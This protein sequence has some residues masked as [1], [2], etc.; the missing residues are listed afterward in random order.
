MMEVHITNSTLVIKF[1]YTQLSLESLFPRP[2]ILLDIQ[3]FDF[4]DLY[5]WVC[6]RCLFG[7]L[8]IRRLS[9]VPSHRSIVSFLFP[10]VPDTLSSYVSLIS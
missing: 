2:P 3:C 9:H 10:D 7:L 1:T 6:G 4:C 8:F 5:M